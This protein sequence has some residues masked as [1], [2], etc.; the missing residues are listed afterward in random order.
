MRDIAV[1]RGDHLLH[2][3]PIPG[4]IAAAYVGALA[5]PP[6]PPPRVGGLGVLAWES[7]DRPLDPIRQTEPGPLQAVW[8]RFEDHDGGLGGPQR[9]IGVEVLVDLL[10]SRPEP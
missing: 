9:R 2:T 6:E 10:P 3:T 8:E 4:D 1:Y 5:R 7:V